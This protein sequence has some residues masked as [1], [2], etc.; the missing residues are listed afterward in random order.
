MTAVFGAGYAAAY[1]AL[2]SDKDY[3]AE[4]DLVERLA[5]ESAVGDVR[6]VLD[7]GCGTGGHSLVLAARGYEV[8]GVD[9]SEEMLAQARRKSAGRARFRRGDVR[10]IDLREQF[11]L[12][13]MMF[14]VLGYM[15]EEAD[16]RAALA[17]AR[18]H[19]RAGG[20]LVLDVWYEPAVL[21]E[22]PSER[23]RV[24]ETERGTI[25]RRSSGKLDEERRRCTV[26]FHVTETRDG[27]GA[28]F[29]E[30][31]SM[32]YFGRR[33]LDRFLE[34]AGFELV[35]FG[36]FPDVDREPDETTW[37]VVAAARAD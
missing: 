34:E 10:S 3:A 29:D 24:I 12:V 17:T 31:H 20:V 33:E 32:R 22:R 13:L 14:A 19:L 27:E 30:E 26:S 1:D 8:V 35:R 25:E 7:L 2:Y 23:V 6:R 4:C 37:N 15:A 16:V 9:R 21:A 11:D 5:R 18:R 28:E 36:S